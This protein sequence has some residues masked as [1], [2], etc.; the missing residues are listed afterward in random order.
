M[1]LDRTMWGMG[2]AGLAMSALALTVPALAVQSKG[3]KRPPRIALSIDNFGS[4]TPAQA[5]PRLAAAFANRA[6]RLSD[7]KV[8]PAASTM[9]PNQVRIAIRAQLP[10]RLRATGTSAATAAPMMSELN[11]TRYNLGAA[12]GWKRFAVSGDV[13]QTRDPTPAGGEQDSA[14]V[15]VSYSLPRFTGR[16]GVSADRETHRVATL[17]DQRGVAVDLGG[18]Y[19]ISRRIAVTGGVRYR[20][21]RQNVPA[22]ADER[23]DSQAVYL[24][25]NFKF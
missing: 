1:V 20:V 14:V 3:G 15:G 6:L 11:P 18:A 2:V 12:V 7:Y 17:G 25:T 5:D 8:T 13:Q 16:L 9:R 23:R 22:L 4:V 19:D 21:N 10:Q 24:G